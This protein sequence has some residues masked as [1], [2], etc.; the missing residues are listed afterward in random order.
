MSSEFSGGHHGVIL[1]ALGEL[2]FGENS[3]LNVGGGAA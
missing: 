1:I 2:H 3:H